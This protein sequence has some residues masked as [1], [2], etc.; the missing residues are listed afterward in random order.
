MIGVTCVYEEVIFSI[1]VKNS[2]FKKKSVWYFVA[3]LLFQR[4]KYQISVWTIIRV[5]FSLISSKMG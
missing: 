5:K 2:W 4:S 1:S 3:E